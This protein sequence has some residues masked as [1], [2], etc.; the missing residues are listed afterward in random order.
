MIW[1]ISVVLKYCF[2]SLPGW[3]LVDGF[4]NLFVGIG[5]YHPLRL[6]IPIIVSEEI[7]KHFFRST[8]FH[9]LAFEVKVFLAVL[10]LIEVLHFLLLSSL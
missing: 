1:N 3:I 8:L 9:F 6:T 4:V 5:I 2:G 7:F 10:P